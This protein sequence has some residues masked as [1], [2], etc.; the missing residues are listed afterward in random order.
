[1]PTSVSRI[2]NWRQAIVRQVNLI[3]LY[4]SCSLFHFKYFSAKNIIL[5]R[6]PSAITCLDLDL[7]FFSEDFAL[8]FNMQTAQEIAD[9]DISA[10]L[11]IAIDIGHGRSVPLWFEVGVAIWG[12]EGPPPSNKKKLIS[13]QNFCVGERLFWREA[14]KKFEFGN[15]KLIRPD[16]LEPALKSI[17]SSRKFALVFHSCRLDLEFLQHLQINLELDYLFDTFYSANKMIGSS[18][19]FRLGDLAKYFG[20]LDIPQPAK[21][22]KSQTIL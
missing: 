3:C 1:V 10:L 8:P 15:S 4:R 14:T 7:P 16:E 18:Q 17:I 21:F 5:S 11:I 13:T 12:H 19:S 2:H 9:I 6:L 20:C 22:C